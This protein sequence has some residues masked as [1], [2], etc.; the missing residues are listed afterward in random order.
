ME[1]SRNRNMLIRLLW[2]IPCA[3]A[4]L[5]VGIYA[6][7]IFPALG[8]A[9]VNILC[10]PL[11]LLE[12]A[13][14]FIENINRRKAYFFASSTIVCTLTSYINAQMDDSEII[15]LAGLP[16]WAKAWLITLLISISAFLVIL[17]RLFRWT[18]EDW[19]NVKGVSRR[20][21]MEKKEARARQSIAKQN[22]LAGLSEQ[23]H[24]H[25]A[26]SAEQRYAH[27][28]EVQTAKEEHVRHR[29]RENYSE[30]QTVRIRIQRFISNT[31]KFLKGI[32]NSTIAKA[33]VVVAVT[34]LFILLPILQLESSGTNSWLENVK[35]M[36]TALLGDRVTT[37][38]D[39]LLYY[40]ILY[41]L[42]VCVAGGIL[43]ILFRTFGHTPQ[44]RDSIGAVLSEKYGAPTAVLIV[45]GMMLA[46]ILGGADLFDGITS[47]WMTL[48]MVILFI[49]VCLTS[50]ELV[51]LALA[52][53]LQPDSLLNK[54]L[55]L[56]FVV[57]LEF[58]TD[59]ILS[60]ITKFRIQS[61][62]S[63]LLYL[64]FPEQNEKLQSRIDSI[65]NKL[66]FK[67]LDDIAD[68]PNNDPK[69][70]NGGFRKFWRKRTWRR[71]K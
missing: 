63:S 35:N 40:V 19:E 42:I 54:L 70:P 33:F 59:F 53:C 15:T 47:I 50:V 68:N 14:G 65:L 41:F 23:K 5:L 1:T 32:L 26:E 8:L 30:S 66:I 7:G 29:Q 36:M 12:L 52:Q 67:E 39:A 25:Q 34:L 44:R 31:L 49:L 4:V 27:K 56:I 22:H 17:I 38:M 20:L 10:I 3:L 57:T 64:V 16:M 24:T 18:Q 28:M 13:I 37:E 45:A 2:L 9:V 55:R 48:F 71:R 46:M 58:F 11:A 69:N 61:L 43:S 62:I 51:R 60:V 6:L 21:R